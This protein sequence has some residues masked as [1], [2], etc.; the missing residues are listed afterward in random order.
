MHEG[1]CRERY[2]KKIRDKRR[3]K[4]DEEGIGR[5]EKIDKEN[6]AKGKTDA[7]DTRREASGVRRK[8]MKTVERER[9]A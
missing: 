6:G 4:K 5:R 8:N 7:C 2:K 9:K 1:E 3:K